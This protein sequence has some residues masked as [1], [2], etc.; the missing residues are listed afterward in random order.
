MACNAELQRRML[1]D[2]RSAS[3]RRAALESLAV[4]ARGGAPDA[5]VVAAAIAQCAVADRSPEVA[6]RCRALAASLG[7]L[8]AAEPDVAAPGPVPR[9]ESLD[10]VVMGEDEEALAA[11]APFALVMADGVV[12]S[13]WTGPD[14]WLHERP[15]PP[16]SYQVL[17]PDALPLEP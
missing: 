14:G 9:G 16:G 4:V 7:L 1:I 8:A 15:A 6:A 12:R 5:R 10:A 13:G 3:V 11:G 2:G 17:D